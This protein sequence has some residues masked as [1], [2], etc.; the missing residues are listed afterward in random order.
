MKANAIGAAFKDPRFAPLALA[1]LDRTSVEVSL[2]SPLE[3]I[4]F[5]SEPTRSLSSNPAVHG[6]SFE[7]G[8]HKSTFLPQVWEDLPDVQN[9]WGTSSRKPACRRI[10]GTR[11]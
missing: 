6:V 1:E 4:S 5:E 10:S 8:W 2:L 7:Y 9:S 3:P 11:K